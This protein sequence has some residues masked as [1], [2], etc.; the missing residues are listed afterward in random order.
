[1]AQRVGDKGILTIRTLDA[2]GDKPLPYLPIPK[3]ENPFLGE[4]GIRVSLGRPALF[5]EQVRA[6][7]KASGTGAMEIMFPMVTTLGD[8]TRAKAI[9][10]EE[11]AA[12]SLPPV[13]LGLMIE[14][15]SA[16]LMAEVFAGVADFFSIGTNDLAQYALAID[17][18]H[19]KLA[20]QADAL[21]PAVLKLISLSVEAIN[22]AGKPI[23]VCGGMAS[24][25]QAV[26]LLLGL[27][28]RKLSVSPMQIPDIKALVRTLSLGDCQELARKALSLQDATEVRALVSNC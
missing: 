16:A 4:R 7:L 18:G 13:K 23:S 17:R 6:I 8:F 11:R 5:R 25:P 22:K 1:M 24:D 28:I 12:L 3:E 9:V 2:G 14:V 10:E 21:S 15:P 19:P 27:G 20:A 26:A